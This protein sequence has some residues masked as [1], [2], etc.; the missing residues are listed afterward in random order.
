MK[1]YNIICNEWCVKFNKYLIRFLISKKINS[2]NEWEKKK[3]IR[4]I[5]LI[6]KINMYKYA[7]LFNYFNRKK[8]ILLYYYYR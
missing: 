7:L 1:C 4:Y 5:M 8:Y 6:I 3:N 2:N